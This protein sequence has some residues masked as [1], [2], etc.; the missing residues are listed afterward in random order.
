MDPIPEIDFGEDVDEEGYG[1]KLG[2]IVLSLFVALLTFGLL[3][4][5]GFRCG[6]LE[7]LSFILEASPTK[8]PSPALPKA[9]ATTPPSPLV[10][11]SATGSK[12][13]ITGIQRSGEVE[14]VTITNQG[15]ATQDM[16]GWALCRAPCEGRFL[17]PQGFLLEP[18]VSVQVF[19]GK[20]EGQAP[21]WGFHW[22][23]ESLWARPHEEALLLDTAGR[24]VSRYSY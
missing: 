10:A 21:A 14:S 16:S 2:L 3:L 7:G 9:I 23:E 4:W 19:S 13:T 24:V 12:V 5:N 20:L 1:K 15:G 22:T 6:K 17:F 11:F 8:A 18:N